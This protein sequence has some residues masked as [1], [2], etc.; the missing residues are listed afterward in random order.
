MS[1]FLKGVSLDQGKETGYFIPCLVGSGNPNDKINSDDKI[2]AEIGCLY[3]DSESGEVYKYVNKDLAWEKLIGENQ[4]DLAIKI[5]MTTNKQEWTDDEK[6]KARLLI[7]AVDETMVDKK[8][9]ALDLD[10]ELVRVVEELPEVGESNCVY[11]VTKS[12]TKESDVFDEYMWVGDTYEFLG[13]KSMTIDL[14]NYVKNTDYA[15]TTTAGVVKI[16]EGNGVKISG[17]VLALTSAANTHIDGKNQNTAITPKNLDYAVKVGLTTNTEILTPEEQE[18]AQTW[19]GLGSIE[20]TLDS[21][22][23]IQNNLIGGDIE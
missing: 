17:G 12:D 23:E 18:A 7:D 9:A 4:L 15:T 3:M 14:T 22:I 19:L 5:G 10:L 13:T 21:I 2:E 6:A 1:K 11:F 20:T 8:I 16:Y